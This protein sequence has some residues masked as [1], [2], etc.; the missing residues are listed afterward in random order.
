MV[1]NEVIKKI[2]NRFNEKRMIENEEEVKH[3][4]AQNELRLNVK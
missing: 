1:D 3:L 4:C 2:K